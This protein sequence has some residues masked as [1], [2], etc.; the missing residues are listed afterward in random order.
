MIFRYAR[1]TTDLKKIEFFYQ[2]ILGLEKLGSFKDHQGYDGIFLGKKAE[3]WH[4]EFTVSN[5][6]PDHKADDDD[7][8]V[9]YPETKEEYNQILHQ[10][11]EYTIKKVQA[12]NSY[13]N[14]NGVTILDPDDFRV[15]ISH[16]K[17]K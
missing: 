17:I 3:N 7:G 11:E 10:I 2:T 9:L 16:L 5:E 4:L 1:H 15:I 8:I 13:W 14:E 6:L 12:K